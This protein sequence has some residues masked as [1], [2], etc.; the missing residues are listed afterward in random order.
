MAEAL[1]YICDLRSNWRKNP[2]VTFWRPENAG[3]AYPLPWAG[4]YTLAE[5]NADPG[6]YWERP[7]GKPKGAL[8]RFPILC[9]EV[10]KF[11]AEPTPGLVDGNVGPIVWQTARIVKA[12]RAAALHLPHERKADQ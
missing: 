12:L 2:C 10:D 4:R 8:I 5:V 11:G 1:Y 9:S 7:Y 6:Y 3:Y